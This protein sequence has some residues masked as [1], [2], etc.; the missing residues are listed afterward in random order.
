[1]S[2]NDPISTSESL[3]QTSSRDSNAPRLAATNYGNQVGLNLGSISNFFVLEDVIHPCVL[4][5]DSSSVSRV[6]SQLYAKIETARVYHKSKHYV[7][8]KVTLYEVLRASALPADARLAAKY[9]LA[10]AHFAVSEF[11]EAAKYF[12]DVARAHRGQEETANSS[13]SDS[14]FWLARSLFNLERYDDASY[15]LQ[16]F[17]IGQDQN[18]AQQL[19]K[20]RLWLGLT[21]ERMKLHEEAKEQME[22]ALTMCI[23]KFGPEHL[24]T[25]ASQH[26]LANFLYKRRAFYEA[27]KLLRSVLDVEERLNGPE[28]AEA[29]KT[30][31]ML[32]LCLA[33]LGRYSDAEPHLQRVF[34]RM[35]SDTNF[36]SNELGE[37]GLVYYWLGRLALKRDDRDS[38]EQAVSLFHRALTGLAANKDLEAEFI[39]CQ[40]YLAR[41]MGH[42]KQFAGAENTLREIIPIIEGTQ[43]GDLVA[44][45]HGLAAN[46]IAQHKVVEAKVTLERLVSTRTPIEHCRHTGEDLAACLHLLGTIY[47]ELERFQD[48]RDCFQRI[49]DVPA[50]GPNHH[51]NSSR[52]WLGRAFYELQELE[53]ARK[54]FTIA[55]EVERQQIR[56]EGH[57]Y[58]QSWLGWT[59]CDLE[60]FDEAEP[61]LT[62]MLAFMS[63]PEKK[64]S[65]RSDFILGRSHYTLGRVAIHRN[66]FHGAIEQFQSAQPMLARCFRLNHHLYLECRYHLAFSYTRLRKYDDARSTFQELLNNDC[67]HT[68]IQNIRS[69]LVPYWLCEISIAQVKYDDGI[70]YGRKALEA[71]GN[72]SSYR[73]VFRREAQMALARCLERREIEECRQLIQQAIKDEPSDTDKESEWYVTSRGVLARSLL[74]CKRYEEACETFK[75]LIPA[76]EA[77]Y[78]YDHWLCSSSRAYLADCLGELGRW[79]EAEPLVIHAAAHQAP[80]PGTFHSLVKAIGNFWVGRRAFNRR[81]F[82]EAEVRFQTARSEWGSLRTKTWESRIFECRHFL[83]RI[84]HQ[85]KRYN[86]ACVLLEEL[87]QQQYEAGYLSEAVD[88][89]YYLG[90]SLHAQNKLDAA[91]VAF[92]KITDLEHDGK[93]VENAVS[94][95]HYYRGHCFYCTKDFKTAKTHFELALERPLDSSLRIRPHYYLTRVFYELK[96]YDEA[97]TQV[98]SM[99]ETKPTNSWWIFGCHYW[100]GRSH[101]ALKNWPDARTHLQ[102]AYDMTIGKIKWQ[103]ASDCRHFLGQA[104]FATRDYAAAK[105]HFQALHSTPGNLSK[106]LLGNSYYLGCCLLELGEVEPARKILAE[107]LIKLK[108]DPSNKLGQMSTRFQLDR[109]LHRLGMC[110]TAER[111]LENVRSFF[112]SRSADGDPTVVLVEY[113]LGLIARKHLQWERA[114][115]LFQQALIKHETFHEKDSM[116]D[117]LACKSHLGYTFFTLKRY[118][119][120]LHLFQQVLEGRKESIEPPHR[121][122]INAQRDVSRTLFEM[123]DFAQAAP[124]VKEALEWEEQVSG[125]EDPACLPIRLL[126]G[127][128]LNGLSDF[129]QAVEV[130]SKAA[131]QCQA[132]KSDP[133]ALNAEHEVSC[134]VLLSHALLQVGRAPEA[135]G[136]ALKA[137]ELD[138]DILQKGSEASG[139]SAEVLELL[140]K[141]KQAA[142]T[143]DEQPALPS[144]EQ[145]DTSSLAA[146]PSSSGQ[147]QDTQ[148]DSQLASS[149][150][151]DNVEP[152]D[153]TVH[154]SA[155]AKTEIEDSPTA[156]NERSTSSA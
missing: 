83:A 30:R 149:P 97:I 134:Y 78:G 85:E 8:A 106:K 6:T 54:H 127:E 132:T 98:K 115:D 116:L 26:H 138:A 24:E 66:N 43:Q 55:Y 68:A 33:Q 57:Y 129:E 99:V 96:M 60:L 121:D 15:Y 152:G 41:T 101:I 120:A 64:P 2:V 140:Q 7:E 125:P 144:S 143:E 34:S 44:S 131:L 146:H 10:R 25:L 155:K 89:Q 128:I 35:N 72:E 84:H 74:R 139:V 100:S 136:Y 47:Y 50:I 77:R 62:P 65:P 153:T 48:A 148:Q 94:A 108:K 109:C 79:S 46:L 70:T 13:L 142:V 61:N 86:D 21:F 126:L 28:R 11:S 5:I 122:I 102:L 51:H 145:A 95:S 81:Q 151:P 91:N 92:Q 111:G 58:I 137:L 150:V 32:A 14:Q 88:S 141:P 59:L 124:L 67:Q 16:D 147:E 107:S 40:R 71:W 23:E 31:C 93:S 22:S 1:M 113:E 9:D 29:I 56:S 63:Q 39:E 4:P 69:I 105:N 37:P 80:D 130:L 119:E 73:G 12:K 3:P 27:Y 38:L 112:E 49:V 76:A 52:F 18:N 45:Y 90:L 118:E 20:G 36:I 117:V 110:E 133:K 135:K 75:L 82:K 42:Q 87:A 17:I 156:E 104:L 114:A 154:V 123:K 53:H 19:T 103:D